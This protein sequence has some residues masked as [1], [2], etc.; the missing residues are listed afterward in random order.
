LHEQNSR[1]GYPFG[2][3][4]KTHAAGGATIAKGWT[5]GLLLFGNANYD[6]HRLGELIPELRT[7]ASPVEQAIVYAKHVFADR[8]ADQYRGLQQIIA[9]KNID[10]VMTDVLFFG[11]L[12]LLLSGE[13]R[14]PVIACG[15]IAP[16]WIDPAFS[17]FTGPDAAPGGRARNIADNET[18]E[19]MRAPGYE[20]VDAVLDRWG[21]TISR[22]FTLNSLYHLP[23]RLLAILH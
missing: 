21:V 23:R 18:F 6:Y 15:V 1:S 8:I 13:S 20:Y 16:S 5:S 19:S 9:R 14:P 4:R 7:A 11:E 17:I 2:R 10:L 12:P 3:P 22:G